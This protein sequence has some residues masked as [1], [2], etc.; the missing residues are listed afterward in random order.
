MDNQ[1]QV[2]DFFQQHLGYDDEEIKLFREN[3]RN[4]TVLSRS[5]ALMN[6]TIV[7]EIIESQG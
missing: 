6:K 3:P 1:D 2:F 7:V 5:P 4:L